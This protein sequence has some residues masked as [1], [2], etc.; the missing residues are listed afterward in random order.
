MNAFTRPHILEFIVNFKRGFNA[1]VL[2]EVFTS[3]NCYHFA[4]ILKDAYP[5]GRIAYSQILGHF[6]LEINGRHYDIAGE[7]EKPIT[8]VTYFDTLYYTDDALY[9]RLLMDCVFK[10][11]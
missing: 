10:L 8:D 11:T 4:V 2:T 7:I 3:G 1:Q 5:E 6:F 9:G